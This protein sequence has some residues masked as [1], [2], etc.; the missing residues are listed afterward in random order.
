MVSGIY[1]ML[2]NMEEKKDNKPSAYA[3]FNENGYAIPGTTSGA[4]IDQQ[5]RHSAPERD[6]RDPSLSSAPG[7]GASR[8]ANNGVHYKR[9]SAR[10][11]A[12]CVCGSGKK[13]K[14]CCSLRT[15]TGKDKADKDYQ[16]WEKDWMAE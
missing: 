15:G 12:P 10:A 2:T 16:S 8:L 6:G 13:Y 3:A 1:F 14:K 5:L 4:M 7:S 9:A 11:N